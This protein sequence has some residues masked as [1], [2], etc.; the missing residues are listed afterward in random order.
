[1]DDD[2]M[3]EVFK[4]LNY[5]GLAKNSLVSKRFRTLIQTHRH[6]FAL[7]DVYHIGMTRCKNPAAIVIFDKWLSPEKYNEWVIRNGYSKQIPLEGVKPNGCRNRTNVF[8]VNATHNHENRPLFQHFLHLLTDPFIYIGTLE[9]TPQ[10]DVLNLLTGAMNTNRG[11]IQCRELIFNLDGNGFVSW[12]KDQVCRYTATNPEHGRIQCNRF[13]FKL[14]YNVQRIIRF[15]KEHVRGE[16]CFDFKNHNRSNRLQCEQD[17][18]N[19]QKF[20][21]W[22]KEHVLCE[23][24]RIDGEISDSNYEELRYYYKLCYSSPC[25]EN[26]FQCCEII[27]EAF[28]SFSSI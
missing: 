12:V 15:M 17:L 13:S 23:E 7:L 10:N 25:F 21:D 3:V 22:L 16:S 18:G 5:C 9:F 8:S 1:M 11:R 24:F 27:H 28:Y 4:Y 2:T 20:I 26:C 14:R 19:P 6:S